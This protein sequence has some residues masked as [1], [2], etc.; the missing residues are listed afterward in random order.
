MQ[1]FKG[2]VVAVVAVTVAFMAFPTDIRLNFLSQEF[3]YPDL[4]K[5]TQQWNAEHLLGEGG[6][7]KVFKGPGEFKCGFKFRVGGEG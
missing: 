4:E 5:A 6:F 3:R 2:A 7:G 1:I